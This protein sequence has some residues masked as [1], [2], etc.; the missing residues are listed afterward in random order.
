MEYLKQGAGLAKF[1]KKVYPL[2]DKILVKVIEDK[3]TQTESGI[4]LPDTLEKEKPILGRVEAIGDSDMI[5][6]K[7]GDHIM[8]NKFSGTEFK[9]GQDDYLILAAADVLAKVEL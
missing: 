4:V 9:I 5:K 7:V 6:V 1:M 8:F 3:P 2:E